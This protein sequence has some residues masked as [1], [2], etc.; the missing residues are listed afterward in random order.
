M[1]KFRAQNGVNS[2]TVLPSRDGRSAISFNVS[3]RPQP[4]LTPSRSLSAE[5]EC[6]MEVAPAIP[7]SQIEA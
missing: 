2:D 1:L 7:I 3:F 5:F 6:Q 4:E